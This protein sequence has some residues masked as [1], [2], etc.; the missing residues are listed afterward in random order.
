MEEIKGTSHA[1]LEA[2]KDEKMKNM[3]KCWNYFGLSH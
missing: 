3:R 2:D 1:K